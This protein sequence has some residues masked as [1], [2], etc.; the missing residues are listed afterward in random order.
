MYPR[1]TGV[2]VLAAVT[3]EGLTGE[4]V[5]LLQ[6]RV[7]GAVRLKAHWAFSQSKVN[8]AAVKIAPLSRMCKASV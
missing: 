4:W 7:Y 3:N 6:E 2:I 5:H 1:L 8:T